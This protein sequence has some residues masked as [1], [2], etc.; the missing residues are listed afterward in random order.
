VT[1]SASSSRRAPRRPSPRAGPVDLDPARRR[2]LRRAVLRF[3]RGGLRPLP[4]RA[5]RQP[6]A[7]L[8]SEVMLQQT[9]AGRVV[10]AY[11]QFL[12]AFPTPA[13]CAAAGVGAVL[14][15]W[16]GLGYHRRARDLHATAVAIVERHGGSVPADL[17]AL[18]ALPG[19]GEYTARAVLVFAFERQAAVVDVNVHRVLARAVA[20]TALSRRDAQRLAD[21]LV[22]PAVWMWNQSLVEL[23]A[24]LCTARRPA[25]G[26]CPLAGLCAWSQNAGATDPA[27][28][29]RPPAPFDGSDRQGRGRLVAALR[30]G[31]V[32]WRGVGV[33]CG[34]P[35][36]APRARRVAE[37]LVADGLARRDRDGA[38]ALP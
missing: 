20:G 15:A 19:V 32:P 25:C 35:E 2:A 31:P 30:R 28:R 3:G 18:R 4:W 26:R 33:A 13:A 23:G 38:L 6:W 8:V 10:D 11:E 9:Q 29:S 16:S 5:T 36:D 7:V 1:L 34:W 24:L 27:P 17:A 21:D 22:P 12:D 37:G 14:R